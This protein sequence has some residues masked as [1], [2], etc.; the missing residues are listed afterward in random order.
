MTTPLAGNANLHDALV[1]AVE[2]SGK[3][4]SLI[5]RPTRKRVGAATRRHERRKATAL[6]RQKT[7]E[8]G[9]V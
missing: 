8:S 5:L 2:K 6:A 7:P 4:D 1:A 3:L 9:G